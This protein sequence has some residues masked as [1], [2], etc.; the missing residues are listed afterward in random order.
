MLKLEVVEALKNRFILQIELQ[1]R[2]MLTR[3]NLKE[4]H[5][6]QDLENRQ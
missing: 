6:G 5:S 1:K 2:I 3:D 4:D